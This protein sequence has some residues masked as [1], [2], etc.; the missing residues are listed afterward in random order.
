MAPTQE[1][2]LRDDKGLASPQSNRGKTPGRFGDRPYRSASG[3]QK[4]AELRA[5]RSEGERMLH[6]RARTFAPHYHPKPVTQIIFVLKRWYRQHR[7]SKPI[8]QLSPPFLARCI[9]FQH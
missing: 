2:E 6:L 3:C 9:A 5:L 1:E 7:R 4:T 8:A